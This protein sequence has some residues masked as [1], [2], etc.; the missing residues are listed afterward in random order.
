MKTPINNFFENLINTISDENSDLHLINISISLLNKF[1]ET[2]DIKLF[3]IL[4]NIPDYNKFKISSLK[5]FIKSIIQ[6]INN[7]K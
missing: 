6:C 5:D 1:V 3:N 2:D 7:N 4:L